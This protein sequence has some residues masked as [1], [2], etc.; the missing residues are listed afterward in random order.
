LIL[1]DLI[2]GIDPKNINNCLFPHL[3]HI[4]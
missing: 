4:V 3:Y 1:I 2:Y